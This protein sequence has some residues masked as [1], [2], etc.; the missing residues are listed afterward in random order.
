MLHKIA[1]LPAESGKIGELLAACAAAG[2]DPVIAMGREAHHP[3]ANRFHRRNPRRTP[4]GAA[5]RADSYPR[6]AP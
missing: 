4:T 3:S 5:S 6:E 1:G 2:I